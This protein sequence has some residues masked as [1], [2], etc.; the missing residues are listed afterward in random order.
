MKTTIRKFT[1]FL[2]SCLLGCS[3]QAQRGPQDTWYETGKVALPT[4][5]DPYDLIVTP[6]GTLLLSD[7]GNDKI[8]ELEANGSLIR[9]FGSLGS[10]N[11]QFNN[12]IELAIG[13]GI[14]ESM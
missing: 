1:Y 9:S 6:E 10:G 5:C 13:P 11:G 14:V 2:T 12:P 4:N 3:V 7:Y 8:H